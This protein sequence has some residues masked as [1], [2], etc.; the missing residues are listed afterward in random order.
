MRRASGI[1]LTPNTNRAG[2]AKL[3]TNDFSDCKACFELRATKVDCMV[4]ARRE[5]HERRVNHRSPVDEH[6]PYAN[7]SDILE[8]QPTQSASRIGW[9]LP[10]RWT[11]CP[12]N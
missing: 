3:I 11:P 9:L 1:Y 12:G 8:R 5:S 10:H 2:R 7:L 4:H 6:D